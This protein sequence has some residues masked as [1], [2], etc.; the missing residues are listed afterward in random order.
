[1]AIIIDNDRRL[2]TLH[3]RSA[4]YQMKADQRGTLLH[5]Y[6]GARTDDSDK[7]Y[8]CQFSDVGFSGN[9]YETG[10]T[11]RGYSLDTLPQEYSCF[12]TGDYRITALKVKNPNGSLAA[13]LR[14]RSHQLLPGKY[15]I[16]GLPA[17]YAQE[18]AETLVIY[19]QDPY[20]GLEAAL[21]YGVMEALDVITR[22]V[23]LTNRGN[24]AVELLKAASL[25]L[26]WQWGDFDCVSFHGRHNMEQNIQRRDVAHGIQSVG[27][28]RGA[29]SHQYN[30]FLMLCG[31]S[32]TETMGECYGFS[33]VYSGEFLMEL[34]RDQ[35]EQTRLVCGIHPDNFSWRLGTQETLWLPEAVMAYSD[36]G[37]GGVSRIFHKA[38]REHLCRGVWKD[39]RRSVLINNW[40]ATYFDFTGDELVSIAQEASKLGVELFVLDDGWFG[41]RDGDKSGLGDWT[42]NEDKLGCTLGELGRRILDAGLQFGLWLEPEGVSE[43]S[44]LYRHHPDWAVAVPGRSP[45]LS[46]SQ[47]VLDFSRTDVQDYIIETVSGL[48]SDAPISYIKWDLNRSICDKFTY[49][50]PSER[51]GEFSHRC[52]LGLYRVLDEL[53]TRFPEVLFE[54][55]CG[56]GGRFDAGMLYYTPQ[57]WG[58][59]NT[60]PIARL[61]IQYGASFGY[62]VSCMGAHVAAVPSHQTGRVTPLNTRACVAMSGSFG[63]ELDPRKLSEAE[64]ETIKEQINTFKQYYDLIHRG[65]YYRLTTPTHSCCTVWE[66]ADPAGTQALITAVYHSAQANPIPVRVQVQGLRDEAWYHVSIGDETSTV[67]GA[68]LRQCGL[69]IPAAKEEYQAWQIMLTMTNRGHNHETEL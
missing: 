16:P 11:D 59:D 10:L 1:M 52:I 25:N 69:V 39:K 19:L 66:T 68:A 57:I 27:S 53:T 56:G 35:M 5:L 21:Y 40:E 7:S 15:A 58:S 26:D 42:P 41:K 43:D 67:S 22:A 62:P 23:C 50:L 14:Y 24:D 34:E 12:G 45:C 20:T 9:P 44:E 33:F 17:L 4:T 51:Q 38:V 36:Q 6:Y 8:F 61:R 54:S 64:R 48:L 65:S 63:Y 30:P 37:L 3:T 13:G 32:A 60:D 2:F 28:V 18:G 47:L 55:C 46:R 31:K 29:S 49:A